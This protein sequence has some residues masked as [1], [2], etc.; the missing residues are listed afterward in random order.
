MKIPKIIHQTW[1]TKEIPYHVYKKEWINSWREFHPDWEYRLWTDEDNRR[2][3]EKE[4]PWFLDIY[5]HYPREIFRADA[6]HYFILYHYGGLYVDLDYV[7]LKN[8]EPLLNDHEVILS[9][10]GKSRMWAHSISNAIM[11][12][13]RKTRFWEVV[14]KELTAHKMLPQ[15]E[16]ATG[17]I[18]LKNAVSKYRGLWLKSWMTRKPFKNELKIHPGDLLCP[19]DWRKH[20]LQHVQKY[21][22]SA[23]LENPRLFFAKA[24]AV[25]F[26][27]HH[28]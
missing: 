17:P 7:C 8:I 16:A 10:V 3:I 1:K 21:P 23:M 19:L 6:V 28:Y 15:V 27:A 11:A 20:S 13:A 25:T 9:F 18:M 22:P 14:F 4:Y 26:W 2:F 12:S 5:D 24:Y